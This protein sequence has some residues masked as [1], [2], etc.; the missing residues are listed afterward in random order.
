MGGAG[1]AMAFRRA[2][3]GVEIETYCSAG[4]RARYGD[5][6]VAISHADHVGERAGATMG[7]GFAGAALA[8]GLA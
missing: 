7:V 6:R 8:R 4:Y 2:L 3:C 1:P 5:E